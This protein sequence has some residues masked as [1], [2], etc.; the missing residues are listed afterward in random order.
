MKTNPLFIQKSLFR[1][2]FLNCCN[3]KAVLPAKQ[4]DRSTGNRASVFEPTWKEVNDRIW[5]DRLKCIPPFRVYEPDP[6]LWHKRKVDCSS[7][8][9]RCGRDERIIYRLGSLRWWNS[10]RMGSEA[11]RVYEIARSLGRGPWPRGG[12]RLHRQLQ[13]PHCRLLWQRWRKIDHRPDLFWGGQ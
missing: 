5:Q 3:T 8:I 2:I 6:C 13:K 9:D 12:I 4:K 11:V 7:S 1:I 10:F